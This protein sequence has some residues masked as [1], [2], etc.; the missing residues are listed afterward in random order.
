LPSDILNRVTK[1]YQP[2]DKKQTGLPSN[3]VP[4]GKKQTGLPS[5]IIN[6]IAKQYHT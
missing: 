2:E 1:E 3:I 6:R 4:E 5:D